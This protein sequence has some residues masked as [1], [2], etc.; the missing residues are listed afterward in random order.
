[1]AHW[2]L[3]CCAKAAHGQKARCVDQPHASEAAAEVAWE[4]ASRSGAVYDDCTVISRRFKPRPPPT[5]AQREKRGKRARC[6][7][8][9]RQLVEDR[10]RA[11]YLKECK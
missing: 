7:R 4:R 2:F 11:K 10:C 5:F 8:A 9:Y 1:M 6:S 3:R